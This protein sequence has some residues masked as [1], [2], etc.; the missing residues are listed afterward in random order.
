MFMEWRRQLKKKETNLSREEGTAME[1]QCWVSTTADKEISVFLA[2][3]VQRCVW[4]MVPS[5][6]HAG[7][8]IWLSS[9]FFCQPTVT[10][11]SSCFLSPLLLSPTRIPSSLSCPL[12]VSTRRL[13]FPDNEQNVMWLRTW[14]GCRHLRASAQDLPPWCAPWSNSAS[15]SPSVCLC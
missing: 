4:V 11:V 15:C 5:W 8:A 14:M 6:N 13:S 12:H 3:K 7:S 9:S 2:P 1:R 10:A